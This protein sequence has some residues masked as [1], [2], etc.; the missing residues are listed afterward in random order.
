MSEGGGARPLV[1]VVGLSAI[2]AVMDEAG[3]LRSADRAFRALAE[4][5]VRMPP[6]AGLDLPPVGGEVHLKGAWIE[7]DPVFAFKVATGFYGNAALG[8]PVGSGLFLVFD[9]EK[10]YPLGLLE[11][12]GWLTEMRT[13][14]AGAL[15]ARHLTHDRP[16]DVALVGAGSQ[17]RFQLR[18]LAGVRDVASVRVW[19]RTVGAAERFRADMSDRLGCPIEVVVGSTPEGAVRGAGLVITV[20]PAR[21]PLVRDEWVSP[22]ATVVAVGSDG[23]GKR[24]LASEL[25]AHADRVVVDRLDQST[26]LGELEAPVREGFMRAGD[27]HAELGDVVSGARPGRE[28]DERIVCDLTGVGAQ[29]AAIAVDAWARL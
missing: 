12:H 6:P 15:A 5:R 9:A 10:G 4:G 24:E 21:E 26:R 13:G 14:A 1:R 2:R 16:L 20:T 7:G 3:A 8:L 18:A 27:V 28:G 17:A 22:G 29:D 19:S 23:P 11:D 25:V